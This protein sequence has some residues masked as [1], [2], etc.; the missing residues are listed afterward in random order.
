M[1]E[2]VKRLASLDALRGFD[3]F[4]I[5][6]GDALLVAVLGSSAL[7]FALFYW[8][9][10]VKGWQ[11]WSFFFRVIGVNSITIYLAQRLIGFRMVNNNLVVP[12]LK[13]VPC[14]GFVR[15]VSAATYIALCWLFLL[16]LYRRKVFLKI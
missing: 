2:K 12:F 7:L 16:W 14:D 3:M 4:W 11:G 10:D 13:L 5:M 1:E 15:I 8:L 6:G 9:V